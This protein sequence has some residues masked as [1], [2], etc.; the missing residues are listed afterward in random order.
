[1][2]KMSYIYCGNVH[3]FLLAFVVPHQSLVDSSPVYLLMSNLLQFSKKH[4]EIILLYLG[5][6]N[7]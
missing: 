3:D 5:G 2:L 6:L 1:M 4:S 7:F